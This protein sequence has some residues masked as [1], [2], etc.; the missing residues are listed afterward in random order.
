MSLQQFQELRDALDKLARHVSILQARI[1][2]VEELSRQQ[3][4]EIAGLKLRAAQ[5]PKAA[6]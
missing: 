2:V 5:K 6:A 4:N 1:E 3:K